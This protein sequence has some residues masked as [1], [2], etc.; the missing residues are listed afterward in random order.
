MTRCSGETWQ[1]SLTS[2]EV[3]EDCPQP[4]PP[5]PDG[6]HPDARHDPLN[7]RPG[8]GKLNATL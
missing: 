8:R 1:G 6:P 7:R 5:L 4:T 3:F 2:F